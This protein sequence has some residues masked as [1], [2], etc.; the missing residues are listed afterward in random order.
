M[1]AII[2]EIHY[3]QRERVQP[4]PLGLTHIAMTCCPAITQQEGPPHQ[5]VALGV[6]SLQNHKPTKPL[7]FT[8]YPVWVFC[9]S[10]GGV[11]GRWTETY[12]VY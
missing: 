11:G 7:L 5:T 2:T 4:N 10:G 12:G 1:K 8:I 9:Y 3:L 6:P